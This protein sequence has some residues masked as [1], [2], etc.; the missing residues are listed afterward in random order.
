MPRSVTRLQLK[1]IRRRELMKGARSAK[2]HNVRVLGLPD[3][4]V[5]QESRKFF[6]ETLWS[7][8]QF[9]PE[10]ILTFGPDGLTG[11]RDHLACWQVGK[12][13]ARKLKVPMYVFTVAPRIRK[14][15]PKWFKARRVNPHYQPKVAP[16]RKATLQIPTP[17]GFKRQVL[18]HYK[19]Q[20]VGHDPYRGFPKYAASLFTRAEYFAK[21]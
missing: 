7:A 16:F 11:H 19:S 15:V 9:K 12:K 10:V 13:L 8:E 14:I 20:L 6:N 1:K 2:I 18:R 21:Q 17:R 4:D 3:G 5:F